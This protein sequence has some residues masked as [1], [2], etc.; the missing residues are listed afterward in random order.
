[1]TEQIVA[2]RFAGSGAGLQPPQ[3][4]VA[5]IMVAH[6]YGVPLDSLMAGTRRDRRAAEARQVAMYL[7]HVVFRMSLGAVARGFGRDRTT[8]RHACRHVEAMR[9]DPERDRLLGWLEMALREMAGE[10]MWSGGAR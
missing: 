8:A 7:A 3:V 9:E 6:V 10:S 4:G 2:E 5:Q 1:M